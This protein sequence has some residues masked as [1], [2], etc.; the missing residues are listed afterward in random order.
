[1]ALIVWNKQRGCGGIVLSANLSKKI[2]I[3][4]KLLHKS[5]IARF[6]RTLGTLTKNGVQIVEG[7]A[8]IK[9][10][11]HNAAFSAAISE[12]EEGV[13][14]G[15]SLAYEM[16]GKGQ[17]PPTVINM[18]S[19]GEESGNLDDMLIKIADDY[20][21]E[22]ERSIRTA[23]SLL[24]PVMILIMGLVVGF[25]VIAML[26]PIFDVSSAIRQQ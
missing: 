5:E 17:F 7:L 19:I 24:E 25:I 18:V 15:G 10:T 20:D 26:L 8:T 16:A 14:K 11:T 2:P 22:L 6:V 23:L 13:R 12:M 21:E 9:E 1:M 4:G 3:L